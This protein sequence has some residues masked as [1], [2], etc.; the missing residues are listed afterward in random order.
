MLSKPTWFSIHSWVGVKLSI[1]LCFIV[2]TGTLAVISHEIDWLTNPAKRVAP[3]SVSD[4]NW[5]AVYEQA[6]TETAKLTPPVSN[7]E[8]IQAPIHPWLVHKS[9]IEMTISNG[10]VCFFIPQ[11]VSI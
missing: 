4:M 9:F 2:A 1:L 5:E 6:L 11:Q 8:S 3:S 10:T 7:I